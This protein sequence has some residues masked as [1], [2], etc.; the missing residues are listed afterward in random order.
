[1]TDGISDSATVYSQNSFKRDPGIAGLVL[2]SSDEP[3]KNVEVLIYGPTGE[4]LATMYTDEDGWYMWQYKHKG[5]WADYTVELPA[6]NLA[7]T[8]TLKGNAF[9]IVDFTVP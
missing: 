5:K 8:V 4:L 6:Y 7:Q 2:N 3:V 9:V 1:V